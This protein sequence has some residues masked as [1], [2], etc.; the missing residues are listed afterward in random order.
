MTCNV[1]GGTLNLT[2]SIMHQKR[3]VGWAPSGPAGELTVDFLGG[4]CEGKPHVWE[5]YKGKE[6]RKEGK[7]GSDSIPVLLYSQ[8]QLWY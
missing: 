2:Q 4:S 1:F 8:F 3:F 6:E 7:E 5:G